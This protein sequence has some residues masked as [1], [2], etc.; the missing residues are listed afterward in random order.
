MS[1]NQ[2]IGI[3]SSHFYCVLDSAMVQYAANQKTGKQ[4][5]IIK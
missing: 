3:V 1:I 5:L 2:C 4:E